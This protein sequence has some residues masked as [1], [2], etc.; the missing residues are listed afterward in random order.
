MTPAAPCRPPQVCSGPAGDGRRIRGAPVLPRRVGD[1]V[2][3]RQ[4][5]L[6]PQRTNDAVRELVKG[7]WDH[8]HC[9]FCWETFAQ[10]GTPRSLAEGFATEDGYHW[11]CRSCFD[12]FRERFGWSLIE[13]G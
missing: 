8:D 5:E 3:G 11:I 7:G 2:L 9:E 13:A 10:E 6:A 4:L 1:A 12:D